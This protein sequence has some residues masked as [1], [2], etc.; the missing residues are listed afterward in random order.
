MAV[1]GAIRRGVLLAWLLVIAAVVVP[2]VVRMAG[3]TPGPGVVI[4]GIDGSERSVLLAQMKRL[5]ALTR[6]GTYQ[7]QFGNWRDKGIYTGVFLTDLIGDTAD[8][9]GIRAVATD[10]YEVTIDRDRV[11]D[12]D[13]PVVLAYAFDGQ[14]V[15]TWADGFRIAV[16]PEDGAVSNEEYHAV[17]AGSY[18]V[19][20]VA[21]LVL[22]SD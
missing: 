10:G 22:L 1:I 3:P 4:V 21:R 16:L 13:Y 19:K 18:W 7:N 6:E 11:L 9:S 5:P 14:E 17:S 15:P 20:N 8:F 2:V 12:R